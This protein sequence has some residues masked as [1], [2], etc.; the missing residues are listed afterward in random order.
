MAKRMYALAGMAGP[1]VSLLTD[2]ICSSFTPGYNPLTES[3]S[4][5]AFGPLA[6]LQTL[7]FFMFGVL[8]IVFALGLRQF[9]QKRRGLGTGITFLVMIGVGFLILGYVH[10]DPPGHRRTIEGMIHICVAALNAFLF[11]V[12]CFLLSFSLKRDAR[13]GNF[14][15]YTIFTAIIGLSLAVGRMRPMTQWV[16]IGLH[17]RLLALNAFLWMELAAV[18][19]LKMEKPDGVLFSTLRLWRRKSL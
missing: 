3:V 15:R 14:S 11:P 8:E 6:W 7:G 19:L 13:W 18:R 16:F 5:E 9:I 1:V 10:T 17:E 4:D 12:A 2:L